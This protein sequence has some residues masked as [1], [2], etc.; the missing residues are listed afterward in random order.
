MNRA[1]PEMRNLAK[2][3]IIYEA[4]G[5]EASG[6]NSTPDFH[7]SE[8]LRQHLATF[9]GRTGF[10]TLLARALVLSRAEV[11]WLSEVRVKA[12]GSLEGVED[13]HARLTPASFME[14]RVVLLAQLLGMLVAFIGENLTFRL[15]REIWPK[16]ALYKLDIIEGGK[17][18]KAE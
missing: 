13:L 12:D 9:M 17:H 10:H 15:V 11:P 16:F 6:T 3:L 1:T 18:E 5:S 2:R 8:K 4:T 7:V 14:G